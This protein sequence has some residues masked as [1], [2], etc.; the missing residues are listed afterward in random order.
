VV[1]AASTATDQNITVVLRG[2]IRTNLAT[3][4]TPQIQFSAIA[5]GAP[6][7]LS[8][9]YFRLVSLGNNSVTSVGNWS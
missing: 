2:I 1:T 5:G 4:F 8:G 6:S 7:V 9:S 3:T